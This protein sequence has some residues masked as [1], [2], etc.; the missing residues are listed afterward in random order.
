MNKEQ[1]YIQWE[2]EYDAA[3]W[4]DILLVVQQVI[5]L[6]VPDVTVESIIN[7]VQTENKISWLQYRVLKSHIQ[8]CELKR[9][10]KFKYGK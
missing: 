3:T 9:F 5:D 1:I 4:D 8:Y 2:R 7:Y 10:M 6:G